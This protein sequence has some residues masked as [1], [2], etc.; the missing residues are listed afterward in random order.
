MEARYTVTSVGGKKAVQKLALDIAA[1]VEKDQT[2]P[3]PV[4]VLKKEHYVHKSYGRIYTPVFDIKSW[5]GMEGPAAEPAAAEPPSAAA[6]APAEEA[7]RRR[8]RSV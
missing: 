3:V 1:Q 8:R 5:I 6:E 4:V 2:K 7:P